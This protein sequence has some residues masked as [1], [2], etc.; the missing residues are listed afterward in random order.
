MTSRATDFSQQTHEQ[1]STRYSVV[2]RVVPRFLSSIWSAKPNAK[3]HPFSIFHSSILRSLFGPKKM[4]QF[5]PQKGEV[6]PHKKIVFPR[7]RLF[8]DPLDPHR[9]KDHHRAS[10]EYSKTAAFRRRACIIRFRSARRR[11]RDVNDATFSPKVSRI[12]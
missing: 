3:S 1:S 9:K 11:K 5:L 7:R 10:T 6:F 12:L 4:V 8:D 2:A